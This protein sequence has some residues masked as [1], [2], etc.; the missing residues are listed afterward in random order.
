M[1]CRR[2]LRARPSQGIECRARTERG[3][4]QLNV[5]VGI[6][7]GGSEFVWAILLNL[8]REATGSGDTGKLVFD[9]IGHE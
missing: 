3:C 4:S 9:R 5:A 6:D 1:R 7:E 2:A 8:K